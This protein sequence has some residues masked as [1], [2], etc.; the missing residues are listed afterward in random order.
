M[1]ESEYLLSA[2]P[3][4]AALPVAAAARVRRL[5]RFCLD[6]ISLSQPE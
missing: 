3:A 6:E 4:L 1:T 5:L 2:D